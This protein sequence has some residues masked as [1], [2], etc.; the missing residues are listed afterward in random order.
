VVNGVSGALR[1]LP[2]QDFSGPKHVEIRKRLW[3]VELH[4]IETARRLAGRTV[5]IK[6]Q[7]G[8]ERVVRAELYYPRGP[9]RFVTDRTDAISSEE[10]SK[11]IPAMIRRTFFV[12]DEMRVGSTTGPKKRIVFAEPPGF[13]K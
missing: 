4:S 8:K 3:M 12:V 11:K 2:E 13:S 10:I 5:T 9:S 6:D 1:A 7:E